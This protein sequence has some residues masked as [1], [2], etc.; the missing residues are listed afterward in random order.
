MNLSKLLIFFRGNKSK[1]AKLLRI[2]RL[3]LSRHIE[4]G[5]DYIIIDGMVYKSMTKINL[6]HLSEIERLRLE[7]HFNSECG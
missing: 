7:D 1:V 4:Q 5:R 6:D 3:T 2:E